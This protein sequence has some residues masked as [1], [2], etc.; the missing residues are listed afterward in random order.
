MADG[1]PLETHLGRPVSV[2]RLQRVYHLAG[3]TQ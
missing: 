3:G 1:R 2:G